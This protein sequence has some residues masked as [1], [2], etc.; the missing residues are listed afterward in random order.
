M[1]LPNP[2][3]EAC[4][5]TLADALRA[6]AAGATRIELCSRLDLDGLSPSLEFL[7]EAQAALGIPIH[8]MV[9]PRAG[10][11][12]YTAEE[13]NEMAAMI[14]SCRAL[15]V[16]G[17][18][19]GILKADR[20]I[21]KE[22]TRHLAALAKP[23]KVC[24]HKAIDQSPDPVVALEQL[25]Q[26]PEI[27]MVLSSGGAATALEGEATLNEM[28]RRAQGQVTVMVAGKVTRE[29]LAELRLRIPASAYHGR[30]IVF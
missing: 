18:V 20:S 24:F 10:N 23:M 22:A 13:L 19:F 9:R 29:N 5:D 17:V 25:L 6:E 7:A 28:I 11:F 30:R 12:C 1:T 27:D 8:A 21:D 14:E 26:L 15:G 2:I 4:V 16:A 3:L